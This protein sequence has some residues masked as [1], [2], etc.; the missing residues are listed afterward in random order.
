[1]QRITLETFLESPEH[2]I[3][4]AA[5]GEYI[6]VSTG[7]GNAVVMIDEAEWEMLR[8]ALNLCTVH[9]E[10]MRTNV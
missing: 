6:A 2:L 8:Q 1:M 7:D 4:S 5:G 10:W 3:A 9:P